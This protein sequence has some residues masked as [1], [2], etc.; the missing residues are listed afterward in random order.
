LSYSGF[1]GV[2]YLGYLLGRAVVH[3]EEHK[4]CALLGLQFAQCGI[5]MLVAVVAVGGQRG[6]GSVG[7]LVKAGGLAGLTA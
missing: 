3:I 6:V 4:G 5:E 2:D 1:R 7:Q